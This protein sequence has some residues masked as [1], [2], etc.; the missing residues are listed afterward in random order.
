M[1]YLFIYLKNPKPDRS[2]SFYPTPLKAFVPNQK[3]RNFSASLDTK[4]WNILRNK[5]RDL[6]QT[7]HQID[8][9]KDGLGTRAPLNSDNLNE[10]AAKLD[11]A[12]IVDETM[13]IS[14]DL[15]WNL[16]I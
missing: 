5:E 1:I 15:L 16:K 11:K 4:N 10:K 8:F 13:V 14:R 12:G 3:L 6:M 2:Q 7:T 9:Y